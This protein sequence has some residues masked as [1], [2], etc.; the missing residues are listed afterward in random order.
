MT[1]YKRMK[2]IFYAGI[3]ALLLSPTLASAQKKA[4]LDNGTRVTVV[5]TEKVTGRTHEIH[6]LITN[7]SAVSV[8]FSLFTQLI[9]GSWNVTHHLDLA[10]GTSYEDVSGFT[11]VT[12]KYVVFSAL[13][14]DWASFPSPF[15]VDKLL[16][17]NNATATTSPT[18]VAT[19]PNG[20]AQALPPGVAPANNQ[21][22]PPGVTP[23]APANNQGLPPGVTPAAP[24]NNQ[25][26]PPGVTPATP[27]NNQ[28]LPPGVTPAPGNKPPF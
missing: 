6:F 24:A 9:N 5:R 27:A 1:V 23:A 26:L 4:D 21:N 8:D 16:A 10:P 13:H 3:L 12:G 14:S 11:G 20:A 7:I 19:P 18:G 15:D 17:A 25:G 22:L 28:G 2:S